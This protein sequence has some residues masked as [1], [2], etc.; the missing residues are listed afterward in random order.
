MLSTHM[1][2][3]MKTLYSFLAPKSFLSHEEKLKSNF[4]SIILTFTLLMGILTSLIAFLANWGYLY[5]I[6]LSQTVISAM[7]LYINK[8]GKTNLASILLSTILTFFT[9][10][11]LLAYGQ[12]IYDY[13]LILYPSIILVASL[14][15]STTMYITIITATILSI[16]LVVHANIIGI[17]HTPFSYYTTYWCFFIVSLIYIIQAIVTRILTNTLLHQ[18]ELAKSNEEKYL[19]IIENIQDIYFEIT[20]DGKILD[21]SPNELLGTHENKETFINTYFQQFFHDKSTYYEFIDTIKKIG[22]INNQSLN[23]TL[24]ENNYYLTVA[25][26]LVYDENNKPL[27]IIG[28]MKDTTRLK[29]LKEQLFQ[30]QKMESIGTLAGGVAHD[31]NNLLT[32]INGHCEIA[33]EKLDDNH[34][35]SND[36]KAIFHAGEKAIFITRQLL[37][38]SKK[39]TSS[40]KIIDLNKNIIDLNKMTRRLIDEDIE[41]ITK[42][43]NKIPNIKADLGNIEQIVLN[44]VVNA[45]DA[46]NMVKKTDHKKQITIETSLRKL[47]DEYIQKHIGLA[48]GTYA[49][50]SITD[51]GIGMDKGTLKNIFEPFYTTKESGT[52]LGLAL[53]YSIIHQNNGNIHVYSEIGQGTSFHILW[54]IATKTENENLGKEKPLSQYYGKETIMMVEDDTNVLDFTIEVLK[55]FGY[56]VY[57]FSDGLKALEELEHGTIQ[58]ELLITDYIMP[59][60]N[61]NELALKAKLINPS[62]QVLYISGYSNQNLTPNINKNCFFLQKPFTVHDLARKVRTVLKESIT[63]SI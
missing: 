39:Q 50:L 44:L 46:V 14:L 47:N 56:R 9:T 61:G 11:Y 26:K 49:Q 5:L 36:L 19:N 20:M 59:S 10:V 31:F 30:A 51:N 57:G 6:I 18:L 1:R 32:I 3:M 54:P 48:A 41:I 42:L 29:K 43:D 40:S 13:A 33:F 12:G 15:L 55:S 53:V 21:I 24:N 45:R 37:S 27:K 8:M 17:V 4:L 60:I 28:S 58:P 38:F 25:A 16:F 2:A 7:L 63:V 22:Y 34:P 62:L 52:G 23:L 35:V